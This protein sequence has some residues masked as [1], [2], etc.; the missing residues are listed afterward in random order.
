MGKVRSY[1]DF[2][3]SMSAL[4]GTSSARL[5]PEVA[6]QWRYLFTNAVRD[7]WER[8]EWL[9]VTP[10]GEARFIGNRLLFSHG[11]DHDEAWTASNITVAKD[12]AVNPLDWRQ[13]ACDLMETTAEAVHNVAQTT[14]ALEQN[15]G[16]VVSVY[17]KYLG[18]EHFLVKV[19]DGASDISAYFNLLTGE[20]SQQSDGVLNAVMQQ[21]ANG[22]WLCRFEFTAETSI[23]NATVTF[24]LAVTD[25]N[26]ELIDSS[27]ATLIDSSGASLITSQEGDGSK[28]LTYEGDSLSGVRLWGAL[29]QQTTHVGRQDRIINYVQS[30][31]DEIELIYDIFKN[32]P[33]GNRMPQRVGFQRSS[34]GAEIIGGYREHQYFLDGVAQNTS[35]T[36][37]A[38]PLYVYYRKRCPRYEGG[39]YSSVSTYAAGDQVYFTDSASK[40]NFYKCVSPTS[41][42]QS[43]ESAP[44][45]WELLPIYDSFFQFSVYKTLA[46]SLMADGQYDKATNTIAYA[47]RMAEDQLDRLMRQQ[48]HM[49]PPKVSTHVT[50]RIR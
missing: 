3:N 28:V 43:P 34:E 5:L 22:F 2:V 4:T 21:M 13:N 38:N 30:G 17:A 37:I 16:Y 35:N 48:D 15:A 18:R 39:D 50:S 49:S 7:I 23:Q 33:V 11:F 12:T 44:G 36:T 26:T 31:E 41:A 45:K 32:P 27:G 8:A 24:S 1:T 10:Y 46:D 6:L 20:I 42:G 47:E 14:L 9:E 29:L 19:N 40:A 25:D